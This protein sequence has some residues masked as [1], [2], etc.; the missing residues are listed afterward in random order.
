MSKVKDVK[1]NA[2]IR[3]ELYKFHAAIYSDLIKG[4]KA[5]GRRFEKLERRICKIEKRK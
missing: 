4:F 1:V 2:E 3:K 5:T